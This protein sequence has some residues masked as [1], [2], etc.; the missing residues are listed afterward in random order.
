[1][2]TFQFSSIPQNYKSP[3][4]D[5]L[6]KKIYSQT[7]FLYFTFSNENQANINSDTQ[8]M[9]TYVEYFFDYLQCFKFITFQISDTKNMNSNYDASKQIINV[10]VCFEG[11]CLII[12]RI[13]IDLFKKIIEKLKKAKISMINYSLN[14]DIIEK[15]EEDYNEIYANEEVSNFCDNFVQIIKKNLFVQTT[16]KS[17][18]GYLIRRHFYPTEYFKDSSFFQFSDQE[19]FKEQEFKTKLNNLLFIQKEKINLNILSQFFNENKISNETNNNDQIIYQDFREEDFIVLRNIESKERAIYYLVIHKESLY[20]FLMKKLYE[21]FDFNREIDFCKNYSHRCFVH[22]YGF[23]KNNGKITGFIYEFMCNHSLYSKDFLKRIE[24]NEIFKYTTINRIYQGIEYLNS[25]ELVHRDIKPSNILID[26]DFIPYISDFE[27]IR[28]IN[29][30][31]DNFTYDF[32]T[33]L[34]A[35]PEQIKKGLISYP[36]DIYSFGQT[37]YFLIERKDMFNLKDTLIYEKLENN[38]IPILN[39]SDNLKNLLKSCVQFHQENR[40]NIN[41]IKSILIDEIKN[42]DNLLDFLLNDKIYIENYQLIQLF[43]HLVV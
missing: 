33:N 27:T 38:Q 13:Y 7:T 32:G 35:S 31:D 14:Y 40:L 28:K 4:Q 11:K 15:E 43:C 24:Y 23:L 22:F 12:E 9:N 39:A 29:D 3:I 2:Q 41:Q 16:I 36:T 30:K 34:Y 5:F 6:L 26:H 10:S 8:N 42:F 21:N 18:I 37:I 20:I 19:H 1:M 17:I 25:N